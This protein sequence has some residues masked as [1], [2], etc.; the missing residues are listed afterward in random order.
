MNQLV[1]FDREGQ[2]LGTVGQ[3]APYQSLRLSPDVSV[4]DQKVTISAVT[5][6]HKDCF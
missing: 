4:A 1:W 6:Y 3:P 2:Q 5:G